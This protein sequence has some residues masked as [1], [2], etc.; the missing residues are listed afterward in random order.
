MLMCDVI[1]SGICVVVEEYDT[2]GCRMRMRKF[3][4][5]ILY[6]SSDVF[7]AVDSTS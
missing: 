3:V 7:D 1:N 2:Q 5:A 6:V 4:A